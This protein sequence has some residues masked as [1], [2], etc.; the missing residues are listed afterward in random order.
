MNSIT[1]CISAETEGE[2]KKFLEKFYGEKVH[3]DNDV[4]E[5]SYVYDNPLESVDIISTLMDNRHEYELDL[6]VSINEE[7]PHIVTDDN[8]NDVI[9][10]V[11]CLFYNNTL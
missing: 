5:W 8:Y 4:D 1:V 7:E 3:M 2:I 6:S 9:K 11:F 10:G